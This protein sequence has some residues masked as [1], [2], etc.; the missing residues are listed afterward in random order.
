MNGNKGI[1]E[2]AVK[3]GID[4]YYAYPMTPATNVLSELAEKQI[5]NNILVAELESEIAVINAGIGSAINRCKSYDRNI[6][7]RI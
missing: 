6:W 3:A 2:G 1:A 5:E 7:R 4:L